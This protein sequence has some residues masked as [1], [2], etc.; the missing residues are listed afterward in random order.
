MRRAWIFQ[1]LSVASRIYILCGD[2]LASGVG[3]EL[4]VMH[5][6]ELSGK[7]AEEQE[8]AK[9]SFSTSLSSSSKK[10]TYDTVISTITLSFR[11]LHGSTRSRRHNLEGRPMGLLEKSTTVPWRRPPFLVTKFFHCLGLASIGWLSSI[12]PHIRLQT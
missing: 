7:L 10:V 2:K 9:T 4:I 8:R 6:Q 11:H 5:L 3:V 1:E 12:S